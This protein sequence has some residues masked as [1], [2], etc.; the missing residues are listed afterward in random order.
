MAAA[1][2]AV[3]AYMQ[4]EEETAYAQMAAAMA[5]PKPPAPVSMNLWGMSGRMDI[6]QMRNQMQM[7]AFERLR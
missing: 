5:P 1:L 2:A 4:L 7:K 6:M 3:T